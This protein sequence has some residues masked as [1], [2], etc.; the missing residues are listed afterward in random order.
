MS[1]PLTVDNENY[2]AFFEIAG[3]KYI[4]MIEKTL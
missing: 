3:Q 1:V 4:L 2:P